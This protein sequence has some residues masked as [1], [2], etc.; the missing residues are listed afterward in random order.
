MKTY[1]ILIFAF[2]IGS[3]TRFDNGMLEDKIPSQN[4]LNLI[5]YDNFDLGFEKIEEGKM[6]NYLMQFIVSNW[7]I[8]SKD[9]IGMSN[10]Y[11]RILFSKSNE[12]CAKYNFNISEYEK[13]V[14]SIDYGNIYSIVNNFDVEPENIVNNLIISDVLKAKLN[15]LNEIINTISNTENVEQIQNSILIFYINNQFDLNNLELKL[16]G[17]YVDVAMHSTKFWLPIYAGG[18]NK[19]SELFSHLEGNCRSNNNQLRKIHWGKLICIDAL[20][21]V[22]T[23]ALSIVNSGGGA[24]LPNPLLGGLPTAGL[25]GVIGGIAG[26]GTYAIASW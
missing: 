12:I 24:A 22:S 5:S 10:E 6:H 25:A 18:E 23:A 7:S 19:L 21:T 26:S 3:C 9:S 16:F 8:C 1:Y 17:A 14:E 13:I 4:N 20:T 15:Q 2:V 11:K